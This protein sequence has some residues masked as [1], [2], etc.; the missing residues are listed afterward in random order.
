[1]ISR[2]RRTGLLAITLLTAGLLTVACDRVPLLAP[3]G[4]TITLTAAATTLPINGTTDIVAQVLEAGGTPPQDGTHVTFITTLGSVSPSDAETHGGQVIV[5]FNAGN[6]NGTA[7]ISASSGGASSGANPIR[8]AIGSAAV[9]RMTIDANPGTVSANGGTS[10]ITSFVLDINGNP[11]PSVQISFVTNAGSI[12]PAIVS[13]DGNGRAQSVLTTNRTAIVTATAGNAIGSPGAT[14][15][16]GGTGA[17]GPTTPTTSAQSASVTVTVNPSNAIT[18]GT[19]SPATPT[20][21]QTVTLPLTYGAAGTATPI[22]RLTVDW[23]DGSS[24]QTFNGQPTAISHQYRNAGSFVIS[25][26]G[27]DSFGDSTSATTSITVGQQP[28]PTV[29]ITPPQ[30]AS[31]GTP[32]T[33]TIATTAPTNTTITSINVDFGDGSQV[34]LGGGGA[35]TSVQHVYNSPGTYTVT[36]VANDSAGG[37][38]SGSTVITVGNI[39]V[40]VTSTQTGATVSFTATVTPTTTTISSFFWNFGDGTN[41]TTTGNTVSHTYAAG[42]GQKT[43]TVTATTPGGQTVNGQTVVT[44]P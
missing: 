38:G 12:S 25:V 37:S 29:T 2:S 30:N 36:A 1:M 35:S 28:R 14:G 22:T 9:G 27:V 6:Q 40:S 16:T 5:K 10:T 20:A 39:V 44:I 33:F 31:V 41:A 34:A 7:V 42:A 26:T 23:G 24:P 21:G 11:L 4:S 15:G 8:V 3:S 19:P 17:T 18:I 32:A 43:V 13:A